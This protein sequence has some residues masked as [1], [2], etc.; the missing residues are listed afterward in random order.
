MRPQLGMSFGE[1]E[2]LQC[3]GI[4]IERMEEVDWEKV[5]LDEWLGILQ[6]NG[7]FPEPGKL[8]PETLTGKESAFDTEGD[9]KEVVERT[10]RR[11]EGVEVDK[12]RKK[13]GKMVKPDVGAE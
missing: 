10:K 4:P 1:A 5:N 3:D 8:T 7:H 6:Q 9:R 2:H 12:L 11:L 13:A